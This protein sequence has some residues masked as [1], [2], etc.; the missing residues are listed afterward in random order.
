M[1]PLAISTA[2]AGLYLPGYLGLELPS[3]T[4]S[5]N[6]D[7]EKKKKTVLI[8]GGSSSVGATAIQLAH[9]SGLNVITTASS[10]NFA[11]VRDLGAVAVF[12]YRSETVVQNIVREVQGLGGEF[13]GIYDAISEEGKSLGPLAGI[14]EGLGL[15]KAGGV[16]IAGV[17]PVEGN[18][19]GVESKF[20]MYLLLSLSSIW[21]TGFRL[22]S[23]R[24]GH[25]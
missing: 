11:L 21:L 22:C 8:W 5:T 7:T 20:G 19:Y 23:L 10:S 6:R 15:D 13:V 9:A 24:F 16:R 17:L 1:L 4:D 12:D 25:S 14:L 2:A 18:K 3:H